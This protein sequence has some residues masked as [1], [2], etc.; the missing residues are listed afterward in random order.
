[1]MPWLERLNA[2]LN[3]GLAGLAGAGLVGL[4]L[5]TVTDMVT[6]YLGYPLAGSYE[7]IGWLS[8]GS[9]AL[10][11]GYTQLHRA[12][13]AIGLLAGRFGPRGQALLD[14]VNSLL[15]LLLFAAVAWYVARYGRVLQ[16]TGSRSETLQAVVYPWVYVVA[17]GGAGLALAL[18]V[19]LLR[20]LARLRPGNGPA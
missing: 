15:G 7:V 9:L 18:L 11:L 14:L 13:V 19:D 12:H 8:A 10:A 6:R 20:A 5:F 2:G 16:A 17:A 1:M 4:M 3:R